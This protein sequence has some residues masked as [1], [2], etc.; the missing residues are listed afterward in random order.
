V[1]NVVHIAITLRGVGLLASR[2]RAC[3]CRRCVTCVSEVA[4]FT[5]TTFALLPVLAWERRV[6]RQWAFQRHAIS[7]VDV[8]RVSSSR[9]SVGSGCNVSVRHGFEP[10]A[11]NAWEVSHWARPFTMQNLAMHIPCKHRAPV[12]RLLW[13]QR[14]QNSTLLRFSASVAGRCALRLTHRA[15]ACSP[16]SVVGGFSRLRLCDHFLLIMYVSL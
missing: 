5:E 8:S 15:T 12:P 16:R 10:N 9:W 4:P 13:A 3:C 7:T 1:L 2:L 11:A 6:A 14:S